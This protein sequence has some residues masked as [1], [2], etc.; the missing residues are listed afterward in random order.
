MLHGQLF[1]GAPRAADVRQG[2]TGDCYFLATLAAIAEREPQA[3]QDMIRQ[4]AP[5]AYRVRFYYLTDAEGPV[6]EEWVLVYDD[7]PIILRRH[8]PLYAQT[9]RIENSK[10]KVLWVGL[11]EKAYALFNDRHPFISPAAG[12]NGIG[13][14][15]VMAD[16]FLA[17]T[18]RT[19]RALSWGSPYAVTLNRDQ[20]PSLS[21]QQRR[22]VDLLWQVMQLADHGQPVT[23]ATRVPQGSESDV[24]PGLQGQ[25]AY[26]VLGTKLGARG[27]RTLILRNPW[28]NYTPADLNHKGDG[29]FEMSME[30]FYQTFFL[31][32]ASV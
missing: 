24:I 17:V 22:D 10:N 20:L 28:G 11:V 31:L 30:L 13:G 18:G 12:Y 27:E 4:V 6:K 8:S 14:G 7:L 25:H 3:I 1:N 5:G 32:C 23:A 16:G 29:V 2:A 15:G 19:Q 21:A 9:P 26:T